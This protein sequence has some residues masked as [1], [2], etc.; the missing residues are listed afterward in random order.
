MHASRI[1]LPLYLLSVAMSG[2]N[3]NRA[4]Q[5]ETAKNG[6]PVQSPLA[7]E[8]KTEKRSY[9]S[10]NDVEI[11]VAI[12]NNTDK[13]TELYLGNAD[14]PGVVQYV[15]FSLRL[16]S[17]THG[18]AERNFFIHGWRRPHP[19]T[20]VLPKR[21]RSHPITLEVRK[22][23]GDSLFAGEY[24]CQVVFRSKELGHSAPIGSN[25]IVFH[26]QS[27]LE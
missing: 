22:S 24:T 7:V 20:T 6:R 17:K 3:G 18:I 11:G 25:E 14:R 23:R 2:C 16:E 13:S 19:V 26:V 10:W 9:R 4:G 12:V 5:S 8:I 1:A 27:D 21:G 15:A